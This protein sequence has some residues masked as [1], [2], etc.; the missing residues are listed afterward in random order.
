MTV[1]LNCLIYGL[2]IITGTAIRSIMLLY[3]IDPVSGFIKNE[4]ALYSALMIVFL[5]AAAVIVFLSANLLKT[6]NELTPRI[7]GIPFSIVC[8]IMAAAIIYE[9][10]FSQ[11]L[12]RASLFQTLPQHLFAAASAVSLLFIAFCKLTKRDFNPIFSVAPVIFW[13]MRLIIIF[14]EFSTI[15]TISDTV[16]ETAGMC[17]ALLT[18]LF[19]S[20]IECEMQ[21]KNH[22]LF[23]ATAMLSGYVSAVSAV[24]RI[25]ADV[26]SVGQAVHLNTVPT[27]TALATAVFS[28][29]FAYTLFVSIKK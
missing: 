6:N 14:T 27:F 24:P 9:T 28:T 21:S 17:L 18:F 22:R 29:V 15:S 16:I 26:M 2:C 19:Y 10:F 1:K 8:I 23:L 7:N 5:V 4:Y 12:D 3:T 25:V 20:K 11:L 13:I